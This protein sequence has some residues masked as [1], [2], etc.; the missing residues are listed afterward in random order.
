MQYK[1]CW[2][3]LFSVLIFLIHFD[4]P[5][6]A[7]TIL[8]SRNS[9]QASISAP[10]YFREGDRIQLKAVLKNMHHKEVTGQVA[11]ALNDDSTRQAVDGW[12][13]N[14]F[15]NQFFTVEPHSNSETNFYIEVPYE[16]G[17]KVQLTLYIRD[18]IY[19]DSLKMNIPVIPTLLT[20]SFIKKS[21]Q[22]W[23]QATT[24]VLQNGKKKPLPQG[25]HL[26]HMGDTL[27]TSL[28]FFKNTHPQEIRIEQL[29]SSGTRVSRKDVDQKFKIDRVK[30][31]LKKGQLVEIE[32][33]ASFSGS[34]INNIT[35][36]KNR[37]GEV[38]QIIGA[39]SVLHIEEK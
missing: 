34:F 24:W 18:S 20:E 27:I 36:V 14:F 1:I 37:K 25:D 4:G 13:R 39:N 28:R 33:I 23:I 26:I 12:F 2:I 6:R 16:Y 19:I 35:I 3:S 29:I 15:P 10:S 30:S 31:S 21:T 5:L 11:L 9:V 7:Q 8:S 22:K 17:R 32:T 38:Q